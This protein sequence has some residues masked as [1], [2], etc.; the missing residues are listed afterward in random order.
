[1]DIAEVINMYGTN[2]DY[3]DMNNGRIY[4]ISEMT[5]DGENY[6]VPVSEDNQT[7]GFVKVNK[8]KVRL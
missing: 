5:D 7:I 4:H 3:Y 8:A 2:S 1:M 6:N